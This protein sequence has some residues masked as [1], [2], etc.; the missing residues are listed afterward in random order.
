MHASKTYEFDNQPQ[1]ITGFIRHLLD[2]LTT[3]LLQYHHESDVLFKVKVIV[4]ELLNNAV[5]HS[6]I[7]HTTIEVS[8]DASKLM[9]IKKDTGEQFALYKKFIESSSRIVVYADAM[10][11]LYAVKED[12]STLRFL[13][14]E[15]FSENID[16]RHLTEHMGLLIITKAAD[17]FTYQYKASINIFSVTIAL[18]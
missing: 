10:H 5:K 12:E 13:C 8:L 3:L 14:K 6:G 2:D 15:H 18:G 17:R 16:V 1:N 11:M 4:S 7:E 9:V